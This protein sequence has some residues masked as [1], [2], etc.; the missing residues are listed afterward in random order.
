VG[1]L[2]FSSF[3]T[4]FYPHTPHICRHSKN[5]KFDWVARPVVAVVVG[6]CSGGDA[7]FDLSRV[8]LVPECQRRVVGG[9][10]RCLLHRQ[11]CS[12][13]AKV[14]GKVGGSCLVLRRKRG[15]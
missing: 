11:G 14:F 9:G 5:A 6:G 1:V 15:P 2:S 12:Q 4:G 10:K 13:G 3:R 8:A 7:R